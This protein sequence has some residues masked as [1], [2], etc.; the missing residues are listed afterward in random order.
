M[1]KAICPLTGSEGCL[2][3]GCLF[4][5]RKYTND[6]MCE[7]QAQTAHLND[8][9]NLLQTIARSGEQHRATHSE[10]I[11]SG[12]KGEATPELLRLTGIKTN[13]VE[14]KES[15]SGT[16]DM[17]GHNEYT[18]RLERPERAGDSDAVV[19]DGVDSRVDSGR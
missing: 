4:Y 10:F 2:E 11:R 19:S 15:T 7:F 6:Y 12:I 13:E 16:S 5:N 3:S 17:A 1:S 18:Q 14:K 9:V 8:M